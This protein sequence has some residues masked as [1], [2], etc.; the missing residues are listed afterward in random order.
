MKFLKILIGIV[1]VLALVVFG[2]GLLLSPKFHIER[3]V[4]AQASPDKLYP[5]VASPRQWKNWSAWNQ[6]DPA[7]TIE[8]T[9]PEA[10]TGAGW[11]WK[12]AQEGDGRMEMTAAEPGKRVGYALYF[13][14]FDKPSTGE[15]RFEPEGSGTRVT[16]TMDGDMGGNPAWRWMGLMMD[17]MVGKDF[18][19][20]LNNLKTLAEKP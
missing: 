10:G 20:G 2:G 12:S 7:M 5:L 14:D 6:R 3:S 13:P 18:E 11:A 15:L 17:K 19:A 16:W 8:Y 9:G 4:V 1:A